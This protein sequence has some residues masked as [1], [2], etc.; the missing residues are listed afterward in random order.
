M[1]GEPPQR[2][3]GGDIPVEMGEFICPFCGRRYPTLEAL[4]AHVRSGHRRPPEVR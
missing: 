2:R 4:H 1:K 3:R